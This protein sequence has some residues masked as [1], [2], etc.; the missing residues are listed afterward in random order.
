MC[1]T[2]NMKRE[3]LNAGWKFHLE[4]DLGSALVSHMQTVTLPHTWNDKDGTSADYRCAVGVYTK[5]LTIYKCIGAAYYLEFGAAFSCAEVYVNKALAGRHEGGFSLFRFDVTKLLKSGENEIEVRVDSRDK[6]G[7][8]PHK[9]DFTFF[10]GLYRGVYLITASQT[11]FDLDYFGSQGVKV[12]PV[13]KDGIAEVDVTAYITNPRKDLKVDISI[14][15]L[16]EKV[17][18]SSAPTQNPRA[19]FRLENPRLWQGKSSPIMY[20][21]RL[22]ITD[23]IRKWDERIIKFGIRRAAADA[24]GFKLNGELLPLR[25]VAMHQDREGVGWA[26]GA[27]QKEQDFALI[28]ELE[29]NTL[30]LAHYQ[31]GQEVYDFA[32]AEGLC[33]WTE[34]PFIS[35]YAGGDENALR[36]MKELIVQN[37]HHP[38]VVCWGIGNEVT[39]EEGDPLPL[40]KKLNALCHKLDPTRFTVQACYMAE[41]AESAVSKAADVVSY[42]HY[43][44]WYVGSTKDNATWLDDFR[45]HFPRRALGL[46]EYGCEGIAGRHALFPRRGDYSLEY[47]A[48]YHE[49][50]A[51]IIAERPWLWATHIWNMFDFASS[52][53]DEGGVKGMNNKGLVSYDR[54]VKKDPFYLYKAYW[55]NVP[56]VHIA[57]GERQ[58]RAGDECVIKVYSNLPKVTLYVGK[59]KVSEAEGGKVFTFRVPLKRILRVAA[60]AEGCRDE[61]K[62][63][64]VKVKKNK[65][66]EEL[67]YSGYPAPTG[68]FS[69]YDKLSEV[70]ANKD[71]EK[72]VKEVLDEAKTYL[73]AR[74]KTMPNISTAMMRM[75]SGMR[76]RRILSMLGDSVPEEM[77]EKL[78]AR[79]NAIEK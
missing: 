30:R 5:T 71:G 25:G 9:A 44:G 51:K 40:L 8:Y 72:L 2:V 23:G 11:R 4:G 58:V 20:E 64:R 54:K 43:F 13:L 74:G 60:V 17:A 46:S 53:R 36:Q 79:L 70:M 38:S 7:I 29:A 31:H 65:G 37:Y 55:S 39:M 56:F 24:D 41:D 61:A 78:N 76:I 32:D 50:M 49:K 63:F 22:S 73:A 1:Y 19:V 77:V 48:D 75:A 66:E 35:G 62:I 3:N 21:A 12:T 10:G 27:E 16:G 34:V 47:Q 18:E 26:V 28:K 69:I 59:T 67:K 68:R 42:N 57:G 15:C 14:T 6:A 33:V 52:L 45:E